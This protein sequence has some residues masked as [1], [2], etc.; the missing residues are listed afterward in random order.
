M[1]PYN[2][3][4]LGQPKEPRLRLWQKSTWQNVRIFGKT[5]YYLGHENKA[6]EYGVLIYYEIYEIYKYICINKVDK[7]T[8]G[9]W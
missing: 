8:G 3:I 5:E 1:T 7:Y 2:N 4:D 6:N 9:K